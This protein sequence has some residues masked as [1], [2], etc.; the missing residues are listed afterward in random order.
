MVKKRIRNV[1]GS[2]IIGAAIV[3]SAIQL[4]T[5]VVRA[6]GCPTYPPGLESCGGC[7][8]VEETVVYVDEVAYRHCFYNCWGCP[9]PGNEPMEIER[10]VVV[11]D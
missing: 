4:N 6:F 3:F 8:L 5:P 9:G 10:E 11:Q 2:M 1:I 7:N